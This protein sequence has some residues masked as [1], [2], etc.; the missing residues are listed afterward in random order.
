M[1]EADTAPTPMMAQYLAIKE[2]NPDCLLFY[3]MGDFYELFFDDAVKAAAALAD[4]IGRGL[5]ELADWMNNRRDAFRL[6]DLD[7][8]ML[9]DIG[10]N[11][12]D[13]RD[14]YA[15]PLWRDPSE[16][17]ARRAVERRTRHGQTEPVGV[18]Q[19]QHQAAL[20]GAQPMRSYPNANRSGR[21]LM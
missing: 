8:R 6:A 13:L 15:G 2:A 18:P 20:F 7:D 14:A 10:L 5:K 4:R 1:S 21:Y 17:L 11:R 3:R 19:M 16:L 9:A 12:S